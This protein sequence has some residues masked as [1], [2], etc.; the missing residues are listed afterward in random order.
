LNGSIIQE[1]PLAKC[2][3]CHDE[4]HPERAKKYDYCTR[5]ECQI[6]NA[7]GLK[8]VAVGVNK[9]AEQFTVLTARV[10]DEMA[11]GKYQD[12][13]RRTF[14]S[15][16]RSPSHAAPARPAADR[17]RK[18]ASEPDEAWADAQLERALSMHFT[19]RK[20]DREI[21]DRLGLRERTVAKMIAAAYATGTR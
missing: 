9:A 10:E 7:R 14:A 18:A 3:T 13:R 11:E 12:P 4:L 21:A 16:V 1:E 15:Q 2:V 6:E 19:G 8:V 17:G 5:P 20:S